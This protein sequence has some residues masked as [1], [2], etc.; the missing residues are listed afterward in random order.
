MGTFFKNRSF[1]HDDYLVGVP[2]RRQSV[3]Y[4][5]ASLLLCTDQNIQS[6]LH[7]VLTLRIQRACRLVQQDH[8]WLADQGPRNRN[9]LLLPARELDASLTYDRLEPLGEQLRVVDE[10]ERVCLTAG[11]AEPVLDLLRGEPCEVDAVAD[12]LANGVREEDRLL[13]DQSDLALVVPSGVEV[14]EVTAGK[15]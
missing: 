1:A 6:L 9:S 7:L 5:N 3:G 14:F 12:V 13:L 8:L 10:S 11:F 4:D 2:D 15:E